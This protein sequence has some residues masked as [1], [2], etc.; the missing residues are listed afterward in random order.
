[1]AAAL[2]LAAATTTSCVVILGLDE[3][4]DKPPFDASRDNNLGQDGNETAA[5]SPCVV[6]TAK[7][8]SCCL[9]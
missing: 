8:G 7:I 5:C 3:P 2:F 1:M 9:Q 6:D 4:R